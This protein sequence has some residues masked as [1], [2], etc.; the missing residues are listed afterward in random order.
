MT[1]DQSSVLFAVVG[2]LLRVGAAVLIYF[3]AR[4]LAHRARAWLHIALPKANIPP[5]MS[6]L[7][8][9]GA[10]Y[11]ILFVAV[12]TGLALIGIPIEALLGASLIIVVIL[13]IALQQSIANLAATIV[14]LL[15]QPFRLGELI[16]GN[17]VLGTVKEIQFFST[18]LVTGDNLEVTIPNSKLQGDNLLNYTRLGKLRIDFVFNVSYRDDLEKVKRVLYEVLKDDARVLADPAPN[19]FV[20][21]LDDDSVEIAARPWV[22]SEDYWTLQWDIPERVKARFDAEGISI[23]LPQR[24]VHLYQPDRLTPSTN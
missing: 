11:G 24:D 12:L 16:K 5:T 22:K 7:A 15:F 3:V 6:Q 9:R 23:P 8:E 4:W 18:V 10:Y 2:F 20:Q 17:G 14:F 21:S 13:G 1:I 19:V